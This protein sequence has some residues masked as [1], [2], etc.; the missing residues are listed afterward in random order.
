MPTDPTT[1][2]AP[3]D[4]GFCARCGVTGCSQPLTDGGDHG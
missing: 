4:D 2:D 3:P 1:T